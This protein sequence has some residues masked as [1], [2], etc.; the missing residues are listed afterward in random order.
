LRS[1][2]IVVAAMSFAVISALGQSKLSPRLD[3]YGGNAYVVVFRAG[4]DMES[5]RERLGEEGFDVIEHPDLRRSD[6]LAQGPLRRLARLAESEDVAYV[7]AASPV[8]LARERVVA[9]AGPLIAEGF[10]GAY[11][12]IRRGWSGSDGGPLELRYNFQSLTGKLDANFARGEIER[13]FREWERYTRLTFVPGGRASDLKTVTISF[14][15]GSHGD[16]Y[17]FDGPGASLAHTFYPA[18]PNPEPVAGNMHFDAAENWNLGRFDLYSVA[19]HETGHALGLGHSD[20]PGAV[21]YPYYHAAFGLTAD[22]IAGIQ[23]LYG[24]RD[25][26]PPSVPPPS[27]PPISPPIP[28]APVTPAAPSADRTPPTLKV[29]SPSTTIVGTTAA[30]VSIAGTAADDT[31]VATVTW[32]TSTGD[33][34][35]ASGTNSWRATVPLYVGTTVIMVR[36][37]DGAGNSAWRSITAT[38]R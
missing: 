30:S 4:A 34:G 26:G 35:T 6:V 33:S 18:P 11:T 22:D 28:S 36:A 31:G 20:Q 8:L 9:C 3:R 7:F 13:A 16:P 12:E 25:A 19:L 2:L 27:T 1:I 29:T 23:D 14:A 10:A 17:P 24:A 21:M 38:R 5:A 37:Y 15:S 32:T